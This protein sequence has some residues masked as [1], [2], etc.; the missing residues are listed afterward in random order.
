[1]IDLLILLLVAG[2][3]GVIA[4]RIAGYGSAGCIGSVVLGFI[5]ALFGTFLARALG[6]PILFA[7]GQTRFPVLWAIIG[8]A[9]FVA[10]LSFLTGSGRKRRKE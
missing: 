8:A 2:F 9:L 7:V 1:M 6:L 3:C 10:V 4:Q 5:G